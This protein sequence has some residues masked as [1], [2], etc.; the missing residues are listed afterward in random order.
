MDNEERSPF[1]TLVLRAQRGDME[2][3]ASLVEHHHAP[4][5]RFCRRLVQDRAA[6]DLTQETMIRAQHALPLLSDPGRFSGWLHGI[7]I[8]LA[9]SW[10]RRQFREPLSLDRLAKTD[11]RD[12]AAHIAQG[13]VG[14]AGGVSLVMLGPEEVVVEAERAARVR[15]AVASLPPALGRTVALHYLDGYSCA[16]IAAALRVPVSTVKTRLYKSRGRL[17][18]VLAPEEHPRA[19][20]PAGRRQKRDTPALSP[21]PPRHTSHGQGGGLPTRTH[22]KGTATMS[23]PDARPTNVP[24]TPS[25]GQPPNVTVPTNVVYCSFC[26]TPHAQVERLIAGP[27]QVYICNRCVG[28]CNDILRREG[29]P[30]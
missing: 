13:A 14:A 18:L 29:I 1:R 4:L 25:A 7:A 21:I 19:A 9:R 12:G 24:P 10:W 3:F 15:Q 26:L 2:A 22:P 11:T 16:E 27:G 20:P 17:R 28:K 8:N 6:E 30:V 23:T 5:L